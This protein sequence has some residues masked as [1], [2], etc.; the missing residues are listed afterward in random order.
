[1]P[2]VNFPEILKQ[3]K[4]DIVNLAQ[5]S[6]KN[7]VKDAKTDAQTI[8]DAMEKKLERWTK[9]LI[10]G[11]LTTADFEWLVYREKDL[12]KMTAL[13]EA[14]LAAIRVDQFKNSVLNMVIDTIFQLVKV[15]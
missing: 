4:T 11:E 5:T 12:I 6:L 14:G 8:L 7:Y 15:L 9:L 3:V 13:K 1:M 2:E 10:Q